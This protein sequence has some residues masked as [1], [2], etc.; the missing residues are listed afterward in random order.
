MLS[1]RDFRRLKFSLRDF[2]LRDV[3][4]AWFFGL[5]PFLFAWLSQEASQKIGWDKNDWSD[6]K[7]LLFCSS[8][9][10]LRF[11]ILSSFTNFRKEFDEMDLVPAK[12]AN[13]RAPHVV[14][15]FYEERL[16]WQS[17]Q[18]MSWILSCAVSGF[19]PS[20]F[21]FIIISFS[22]VSFSGVVI[23][24][25]F[26]S[27]R[28]QLTKNAIRHFWW[29][30]MTGFLLLFRILWYEGFFLYSSASVSSYQGWRGPCP[31]PVMCWDER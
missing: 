25:N 9:S 4:S 1:L 11:F 15:N 24:S 2:V 20:L 23:A 30:W 16:N 3:Q 5:A 10:L 12:Q 14:I 26:S 7:L 6:P 27:Q 13:A 22:I 8:Y 29:S 19:F 31:F 17:D 28:F 21:F 18:N